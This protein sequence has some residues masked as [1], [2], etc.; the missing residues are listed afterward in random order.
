[1][2]EPCGILIVNKHVGVTSHD[3]VGQVRRLYHTRRVGHTGT[4]DPLAS[5]VL[6]VLVGRAAKAAEYLVCDG[7]SYRAVLHLGMTSDTEDMTG[8]ILTHTDRL[9]ASEEVQRVCLGFIGE[10][11]QIPPM[12]SALKVNGQKLCDLARKGVSIERKP[13]KI[14]IH[15]LHCHATDTPERYILDVTCSSGTYIRTLCADIGN[16]LGCG[17]L[18]E[19]LTR[20]SAGGFT[21]SDSLSLSELEAMTEEQRLTRLLPTESLFASLPAL[22]LPGFYEKLCRNGCEIYQKKLRTDY[23]VGQ[24]LRLCSDDG[25]FF[26]IG[27]IRDFPEGSAAKAIK[28]FNLET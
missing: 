17:G 27:E 3:V 20:T 22:S 24:K 28:F 4:L 10:T 19:E 6:V 15:S 26:A 23:P 9:P 21:L 25:V 2:T 11:E 18:M 8:T 16:A 5:G 14:T 7:K 12:Y 13:R 1:M